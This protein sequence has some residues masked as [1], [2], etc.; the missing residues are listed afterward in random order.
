MHIVSAPN[1]APVAGDGR[2]ALLEQIRAGKNLRPV[3]SRAQRPEVPNDEKFTREVNALTD[4]LA[5]AME[6][7]FKATQCESC[8]FDIILAKADFFQVGE[9]FL[10]ASGD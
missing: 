3:A 9:F 8:E 7:R 4:A 10:T 1:A 2:N 5:R 6:M